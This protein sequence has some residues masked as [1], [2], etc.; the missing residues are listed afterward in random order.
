MPQI[1]DLT[2]QLKEQGHDTAAIL[3]D[4]EFI[5]IAMGSI[6]GARRAINK[7]KK[8]LNK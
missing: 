6:E 7:A 1:E 3:Y 2:K 8:Y 4:F 5:E